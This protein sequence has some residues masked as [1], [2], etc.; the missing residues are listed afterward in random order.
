MRDDHGRDGQYH[1]FQPEK[2]GEA[3]GFQLP[4]RLKKTVLSG[5]KGENA[6]EQQDKKSGG[7]E[8]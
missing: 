2:R 4:E 6:H 7:G 5:H 1:D 8:S 3:G